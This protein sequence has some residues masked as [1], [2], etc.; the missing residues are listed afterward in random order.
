MISKLRLLFGLEE[1]SEPTRSAAET[2]TVRRIVREIDQLEPERARFVAAFAFILARVAYADLDIS[3]EETRKMERIV[4][5]VGGLDEAQA[6]LAV[7]IAKTQ[8]LLK[9]GTENYVVTRSLKSSAAREEK[10]RL[11]HCLFAVSAADES[12]SLAEEE[13]I[14]SIST[15]LGFEHH[16]FSEIRSQY[17]AKRNILRQ[18]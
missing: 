12:I 17:N 14:R 15:E 7:Q 2:E 3:D 13:E 8:Q 1:G 5:E 18:L 11:L 4:S 10:E 16:E 9:G 6:I